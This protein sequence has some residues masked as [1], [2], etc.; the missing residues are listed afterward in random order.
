LL[1]EGVV[2]AQIDTRKGID[3]RCLGVRDRATLNAV[4]DSPVA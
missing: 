1:L 3:L 2:N 4:G